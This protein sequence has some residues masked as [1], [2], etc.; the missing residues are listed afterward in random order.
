MEQ[1]LFS[2]QNIGSCFSAKLNGHLDKLTE[3]FYVS[4]CDPHCKSCD[5]DSKCVS[6]KCDEGYMFDSASKS[7]KSKSIY[8]QEQTYNIKSG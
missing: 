4:E 2:M 3:N 7:C 6:G 5:A 8:Y 1:E